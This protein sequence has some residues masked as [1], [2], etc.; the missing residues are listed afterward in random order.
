MEV[1]PEDHA[2]CPCCGTHFAYDDVGHSFRELRNLWLRED[3][4]WF[5]IE[6][7]YF[8]RQNEWNAWDQL[9]T[10]GMEYDVPSPHR[11]VYSVRIPAKSVSDISVWGGGEGCRAS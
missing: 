1:P 3:G 10:A 4:R 7:P 5:N 11:R 8:V 2:I 9:D 6:N